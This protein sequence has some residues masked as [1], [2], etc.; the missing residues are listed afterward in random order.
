M[1]IAVKIFTSARVIMLRKHCG[2]R[3]GEIAQTGIDAGKQS[4]LIQKEPAGRTGIYQAD[5]GKLENGAAN[6]IFR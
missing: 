4:G 6:N 1:P 2:L 5:I 3:V